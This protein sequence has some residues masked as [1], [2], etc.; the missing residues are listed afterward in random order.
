MADEAVIRKL[1]GIL[2]EKTKQI[3]GNNKNSTDIVL[4]SIVPLL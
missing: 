4:K 2:Q 3:D 1:E